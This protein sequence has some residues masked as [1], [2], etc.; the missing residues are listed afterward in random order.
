MSG[1]NL[2][3]ETVLLPLG[4]LIAAAN[5]IGWT[6]VDYVQKGVFS[7]YGLRMALFVA[8]ATLALYIVVRLAHRFAGQDAA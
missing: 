8:G 1:K 2:R 4:L 5:L 7:L 6:T 3:S